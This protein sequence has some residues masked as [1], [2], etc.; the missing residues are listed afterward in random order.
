MNNI[1]YKFLETTYYKSQITKRFNALKGF[2][3]NKFFNSPQSNLNPEDSQWLNSLGEDFLKNFTKLNIYQTLSKLEKDIKVLQ[4][5]TIYL[6]FEMPDEEK[7]KLGSYLRQNFKKDLI[8][9]IKLD[10]NL[11][12]GAAFSWKGIYKDYSL[13]SRIDQN[14]EQ[15][16]S[17]LKSLS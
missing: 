4:T 13:R 5:L 8:F 12:G 14:H 2:L 10:P 17:S 3:Q 1:L 7:D 11:I 15:I 9:E 16:L 6:S